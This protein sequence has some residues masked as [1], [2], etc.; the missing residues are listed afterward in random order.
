MLARSR[1]VA[2][3]L[4]FALSLGCGDGG[5]DGMQDG[6]GAGDGAD[7]VAGRY[8]VTS[9]FDLSQSEAI[10]ALIGDALAPLSDFRDDPAG[11]LIAVLESTDAPV[12]T[13]LLD[14]VPDSLRGLLVDAVNDY[15]FD[16]LYEGVPVADELA[17]WTDDLATMLTRFDVVTELGVGTL[18]AAG[19][20]SASHTLAAISFQLRGAT[21]LVDTPALLD[22]LTS[23][24]NVSCNVELGDG[25]GRIDI[26]AH[27][28]HLPLGNFAVV[29]FNQGLE[30][31]LGVANTRAALGLLVDC[32]ALAADVAGKCLGP[33]CIGHEA[34][35]EAFCDAGLDALAAE[36]EARIASIDFAELRLSAGAAEVADAAAGDG[37]IDR[38]DQGQWQTELDVDGRAV[39]VPASF[40]AT[41]AASS[42]DAPE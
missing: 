28:F 24:R 19:N 26:G 36:V 2:L 25:G 30:E 21:R 40:V 41:R 37:L 15:V 3:A 31:T 17:T 27:A 5:G 13:D 14:A 11:S 39:P 29:A 33:V 34:E 9:S 4:P 20:A 12:L 8:E 22:Q 35:L 23:A 42:T 32:G 16:Q 10:P 6:P 7:P 18:D 1:L 38:M